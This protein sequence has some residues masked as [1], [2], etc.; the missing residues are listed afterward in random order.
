MKMKDARKG[1]ASTKGHQRVLNSL[2]VLAKNEPFLGEIVAMR[3]ALG[4]PDHGFAR[5]PDD[6]SLLIAQ[7]PDRA[8]DDRYDPSKDQQL[9]EMVDELCRAYQLDALAYSAPIRF[10]VKY[11]RMPDPQ[12][13]DLLAIHPIELVKDSIQ[14]PMAFDLSPL[15]QST[16]HALTI[17][18]SPYASLN[19]ILDFVKKNSAHIRQI[20]N[21][22][23]VQTAKLRKIRDRKAA[24][25]YAFIYEHRSLSLAQIADL[26]QQNFNVFMDEGNITKAISIEKNERKEMYRT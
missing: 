22:Y 24:E 17:T 16:D 13:A 18:V 25:R 10:F 11:N 19:D 5:I 1:K 8:A 2:K 26:V 4:I 23:A 20:Q 15:T 9:Y 12:G 21:Q 7:Y 3:H 14:D 6:T